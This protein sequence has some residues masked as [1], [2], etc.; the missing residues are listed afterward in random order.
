MKN[1]I[2]FLLVILALGCE[3]EIKIKDKSFK[4]QLVANCIIDTDN[5]FSVLVCQSTRI[6]DTAVTLVGNA[7]VELWLGNIFLENLPYSGD[8]YYKS[9]I[10]KPIPGKAYQ[11][12][13]SAPGFTD[14][15]AFDTIPKPVEV[16]DATYI[17]NFKSDGNEDSNADMFI[18]FTDPVNEKNYYEL[19]FYTKKVT[20]D[21]WDLND[22][23]TIIQNY[24]EF[25]TDDPILKAEGDM[26]YKP[27]SI[28]FSDELF[29]GKSQKMVFNIYTY[30]GG[31]YYGVT[32]F[33]HGAD[34]IAELRSIS[35]SYYQYLKKWTRHL[36]NQ[37]INL[38]IG[39]SQEL[40]D[41]L[42][43]GE[44]VNMYSNV[45]NGYGI[46]AGYSKSS[47]VMR[48]ID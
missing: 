32:D 45:Q 29:N 21:S 25:T 3:K 15:I 13:L 20:Y 23:V 28:F 38:S 17:F 16:N 4:P 40:R 22:T 34:K 19:I 8:G 37:G 12:K 44:P 11:L 46:F 33:D 9:S 30:G 7:T 5:M 10:N 27:T 31:F 6:T 43:T 42:F 39:D 36:Y 47:F 18:E 35:F 48:R 14:I 41:F 24:N 1:R 26:A 2:V